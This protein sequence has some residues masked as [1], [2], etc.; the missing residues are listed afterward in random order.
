MRHREV[1][2]PELPDA[3]RP[4]AGHAR[5]LCRGIPDRPA[6]SMFPGQS[7]ASRREGVWVRGAGEHMMQRACLLEPV[8][9]T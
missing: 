9:R 6:K 4:N 7:D 3:F 8:T 2:I 1:S 5:A